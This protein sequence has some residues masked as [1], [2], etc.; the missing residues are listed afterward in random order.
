MPVYEYRGVNER[1]KKLKG[2]LDAEN[3]RQLRELLRRDG[4]FLTEYVEEGASGSQRKRADSAEATG[5]RE[6]ELSRLFQRV[7]LMDVAVVTR[8]L[9]T[10]VRA[11]VPVVESLEAAVDQT[12]NPRLKRVLASI[13]QDVNEGKA[14]W[15]SLARH[16]KVFS[17]LYINMVRAGES[18]GTL[19]LVFERLADFIEGQVA[20]RSKLVGALTYPVIM[21]GIAV[22][23]ISLMMTVVVPRITEMFN[24]MGARL[25]LLTRILIGTS[26]FFVGWWWAM[27]L[28]FIGGVTAWRR[29]GRT[30]AGRRRI[31]EWKLRVPVFGEL[32]RM[33]AV[34]RMS[35]TFATLLASGVPLLVALD[36]V[37]SVLNNVV[38]E[39]VVENARTAIREGES[40]AGAMEK[41]KQFPSMVTHMIAIGERTGQLENML[42]NVARAYETQVD[43]RVTQLT[44]ILEPLMIVGMGIGV[45]FLVFAI[46][47]PMLQMN[48]VI[49]GA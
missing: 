24:E 32:V 35:R 5:T 28:A 37:R 42:A 10:L 22:L 13:K 11:G 46:L 18:S 15:E 6:V 25:P 33:V 48:E 16:P 34:A 49:T 26:D 27:L 30:E 19:D 39:E 45:A 40:I 29:W 2:V 21:L 1:G 36:I 23:I 31:D 7:K 4:I 47:M 8:Q 41:G 9:A 43:S 17:S 20:L 3:P 38:L 12:E 14:L 44:A